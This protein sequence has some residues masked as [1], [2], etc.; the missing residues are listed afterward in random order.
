MA[1]LVQRI[2]RAGVVTT[3]D[4]DF[5]GNLLS[6]QRQLRQQYKTMLDWSATVPLETEV[7]TSSTTFDALNRPYVGDHARRQRLSSDLQRGQPARAEWTSTSRARPTATPF[8]TNIDYNA[9]G[10]RAA[11]RVRQR[12][13]HRIH[14]RSLTFRLTSLSTTRGIDQALL[15]DLGYTYDP[16]GN[17]TQI[18]DGAQQTIYFNNQVVTP[19]NDYTYDAIYRLIQRHGARAH[20]TGVPAPDDL[21]RSSRMRLPQPG[22]GQAM[23]NYAE[24]VPVRCGRQLP[25][26]S[27]IKRRTATGRAATATTKRARSN[28]A[29]RT[30]A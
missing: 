28:R 23:R 10:Q 11:D 17:I 8:V 30:T 13:Q 3:D 1:R 7:F 9:K 18:Q 22:D 29:R 12:R 15:Q 2:D 21:E 27:F 24:T 16:V 19:S 5:K 20:R 25:G 26:S 4:Y 14:L 6:S